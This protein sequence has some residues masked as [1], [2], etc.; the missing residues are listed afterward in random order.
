MG[1]YLCRYESR[2]YGVENS[3]KRSCLS[4]SRIFFYLSK[5][6]KIGKLRFCCCNLTH[7][8]SSHFAASLRCVNLACITAAKAKSLGCVSTPAQSYAMGKGTSLLLAFKYQT[9][10][11]IILVDLFAENGPLFYQIFV[12][13][14]FSNVTSNLLRRC[15]VFTLVIF[16]FFPFLL[17]QNDFS[18][19]TPLPHLWPAVKNCFSAAYVAFGRPFL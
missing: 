6:I 18:N 11:I 1:F 12:F 5:D 4:F 13:G 16:H 17:T 14:L 3:T 2:K 19:L 9:F 15:H 10:K 8:L 7:L